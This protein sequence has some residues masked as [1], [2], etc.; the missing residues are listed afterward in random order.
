M[1]TIPPVIRQMVVCD[2]V[3]NGETGR[4]L[5]ILGI[6]HRII[7]T[8]GEVYPLMHPQL[9]VYVVLSGGVGTGR[10]QIVVSEADTERAI[11]GTHV[12]DLTYPTD[13]HQIAVLVLRLEDCI[14]PEPGLYWIEFHSDGDIIRRE[15]VTLG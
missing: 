9:C 5:N 8:P 1:A 6:I 2:D 10:I 4:R 15:P 14:F 3:G 7:P 13:R 12:H 11:F